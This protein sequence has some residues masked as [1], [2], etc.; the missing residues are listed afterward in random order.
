MISSIAFMSAVKSGATNVNPHQKL[1]DTSKDVS[2]RLYTSLMSSKNWFAVQDYDH[3][4][5]DGESVL[6]E[7][8]QVITSMSAGGYIHGTT[9]EL[10]SALAQYSLSEAAE[11][12][13]SVKSYVESN[14][15]PDSKS[16][17]YHIIGSYLV[18]AV[19]KDNDST[20]LISHLMAEVKNF[21]NKN[22]R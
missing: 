14:F 2:S 19:Y 6:T 16:K 13:S 18:K 3:I 11:L 12:I 1:K 4:V 10:F 20:N 21:F 5:V 22:N 17:L 7:F 9:E 15:D 8:S